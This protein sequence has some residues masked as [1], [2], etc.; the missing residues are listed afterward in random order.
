MIGDRGAGEIVDE[1]ADR[2]VAL[3]PL[4]E[5]DDVAL[6]EVVGEERTDDEVNGLVRLLSEDVGRYPADRA[7]GRCGF[8]RDGDG[9]GVDV[10]AGEFDSHA[11]RA[12]PALDPAHRVA[13]AAA[14]VEDV[15]RLGCARGRGSVEPLENGPVAKEPAIEALKIAQAGA[16]FLAGA[17]LIDHFGELGTPAEIDRLR[18]HETSWSP[19]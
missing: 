9:V 14:Y 1:P 6:D 12:G 8:G 17:R 11:A 5:A 16:E 15:E 3:H 7:C 18:R 4:D 2:R 10:E 19:R 13:V